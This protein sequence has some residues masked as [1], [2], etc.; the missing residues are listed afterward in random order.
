MFENKPCVPDDEI[1]QRR[2]TD[3]LAEVVVEPAVS[4][5]QSS[6][7]A[8]IS[9]LAELSDPRLVEM[10]GKLYSIDIKEILDA[11]KLNGL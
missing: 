11:Q 10:L 3:R 4:L 8:L 6:R 7:N 5:T 9:G 2:L 1:F